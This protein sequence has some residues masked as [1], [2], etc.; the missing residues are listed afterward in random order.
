MN[1]TLRIPD[2]FA[3]RFD[4]EDLARRALE[5]LALEEFRAGRLTKPDL[6]RLLDL[7]APAGLD[8]FLQ[9]HGISTSETEGGP[10][11]PGGLDLPARMRA[12]RVGKTLAGLDP[13]AL[14]REGRR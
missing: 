10:E 6:C 12:F 3:E 2:D 4:A 14:I 13:V 11:Q 7:T 5:A 9:A 1:V 8:L